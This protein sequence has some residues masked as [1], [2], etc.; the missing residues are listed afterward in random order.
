MAIRVL[1]D[2]N[3]REL[4]AQALEQRGQAVVR[5]AMVRDLDRLDVWQRERQQR[6]ALGVAGEQQIEAAGADDR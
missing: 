5:A 6:L 2:G 3:R 4:G 1:A